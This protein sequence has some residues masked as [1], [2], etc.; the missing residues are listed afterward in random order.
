MGDL[1][2]YQLLFCRIS[3]PSTIFPKEPLFNPP[4]VFSPRDAKKTFSTSFPS[5]QGLNKNP[6]WIQPVLLMMLKADSKKIK[7]Q[8][9]TNKY[10]YIYSNANH[11]SILF[12]FN[13]FCFPIPGI[14]ASALASW[15]FLYRQSEMAMKNDLF[16]LQEHQILG[17]MNFWISRGILNVANLATKY[18]TREAKSSI[19]VMG[20]I[21][22]INGF[23]NILM[24]TTFPSTHFEVKERIQSHVFLGCWSVELHSKSMRC[25]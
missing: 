20:F 5:S 11:Q 25:L 14:L 23:T 17:V 22:D 12:S 21:W 13:F 2:P 6:W 10:I 16:G 1:L 9:P 4:K 7:C 24:F 3:E 15:W 19:I 8:S 18:A